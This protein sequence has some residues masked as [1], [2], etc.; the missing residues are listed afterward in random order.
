MPE[1]WARGSSIILSIHKKAERAVCNNYRPITLLNVTYKILSKLINYRLKDYV[2]KKVTDYQCGFKPNRSTIDHIFTIRQALEKCTEYGIDLHM[3]FIDFRQ[4]FDSID[5][6][7][8]VE[9]FSDLGIPQ[10]LTNLVMM[11]LT[12]TKAKV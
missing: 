5:R 7:K 3:L 6:S 11:I 9:I 2:E 10:K 12:N 1:E 8:I 4:A